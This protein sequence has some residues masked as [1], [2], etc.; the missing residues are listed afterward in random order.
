[1]YAIIDVYSRLVTGIYVGL[2]GPSWIGA[3]MALDNMI[4]DKVEYCKKYGIKITE[5][6]WPSYKL[7]AKS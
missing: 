2:E 1:M 3:M 6:E 7:F 5:E 4:E